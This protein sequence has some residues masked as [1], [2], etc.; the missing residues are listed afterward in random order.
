MKQLSGILILSI[1]ITG[2][3]IYSFTGASIS[4]DTKT[5]SIQYFENFS[6]IAP[7]TLS[8]T[9][10]EAL[11]DRFMNQTNLSL[12]KS[13][14]DLSYEGSIVKNG[15]LIKPVAIQGNNSSAQTRLSI[16]VNVKFVNNND[17]KQN[18]EKQ[19]TKYE[20]YSNNYDISEVEDDLIEK[21]NEQLLQVIF[22]SSVNN[23]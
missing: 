9:F 12:V 5:V 2:C 6:A 15:Y 16:T 18:F 17:E 1:L 4:A 22:D 3:G 14:G 19:F 11:K 21:I 20:D 8:Q 7:P 23:W 10:T 13:D